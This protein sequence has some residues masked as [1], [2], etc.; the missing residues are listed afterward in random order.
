MASKILENNNIS[1]I[2]YQKIKK[3]FL[4]R[5]NNIVVFNMAKNNNVVYQTVFRGKTKTIHFFN[6]NKKVVV[7]GVEYKNTNSVTADVFE[8]FD[9]F[10]VF[11]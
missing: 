6:G 3:M 7:G 5:N 8:K 1:E 11:G 10:I 9:E 2:A 4:F